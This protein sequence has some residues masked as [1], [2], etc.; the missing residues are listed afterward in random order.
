MKAALAVRIAGWESLQLVDNISG[1]VKK[2]REGGYHFRKPGSQKKG[3][4]R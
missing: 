4:G 3:S 1:T 2:S